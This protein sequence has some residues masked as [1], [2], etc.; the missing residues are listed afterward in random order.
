MDLNDKRKRRLFYNKKWI[1]EKRRKLIETNDDGGS[2]N[3]VNESSSDASEGNRPDSIE[4]LQSCNAG[5]QRNC[6]LT[7]QLDQ[8]LNNNLSSGNDAE[9]DLLEL[10]FENVYTSSDSAADEDSSCLLDSLRQ[11]ANIYEVKGNAIDSLLK[12][13]RQ[14]GH[15]NIPISSRTLL[16]TPRQVDLIRV[17]DMDY[18]H[19][20]LATML[21]SAL[22]KY[23][24]DDV[25]SLDRII[26]S[27]NIDGFPLFKSSNTSVWPVLGAVTNLKPMKP[28]LIT[29]T[30][31]KSKPSNL[32][33]LNETMIDLNNLLINGFDYNER[34]FGVT[35]SCIICDAPAK[36]FVKRVKQYSGY[37]GC[38]KC[39]Q[40]GLYIGRMTYPET[41]NLTYRTDS[42]FRNQ[43]QEEHHK[44]DER[45]PFLNLPID[46][47][48][49]F[50]IDYMHQ[51]CLGVMKKLIICWMRGPRS[52]ARL[53]GGLIDQISTRLMSFVQFVPREF[54]RKPR[55]LDE[56]DRWKATEFRQ[57]LLY[58]GPFALK[59]VLP[60]NLYKH[61]MCLS[62]AVN[63]LV[64]K[65][66]ASHHSNY[67][68]QLLTYFV[69][70][71]SVLYGQEF[72]VY[73]IHSLVHLKNEADI[74][75]CLDNCAAWPFESYMQQL[76]RKVRMGNNPAAQL[77]KRV[78]ESM[79]QVSNVHTTK[80]NKIRFKKPNNMYCTDSGRYCEVIRPINTEEKA[81]LCRVYH[82]SE[83]SFRYPCNSDIIGHAKFSK[84]NYN[85]KTLAADKLVIRCM[86]LP[87]IEENKVVFLPLQHD[88]Q[89]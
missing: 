17:S 37:Y 71:C 4:N 49:D 22:K 53:S 38:D 66:L 58:T 41:D 46:M 74:F 12:I 62:V 36:A 47:V 50:P 34:H 45:S 88:F 83:Y 89:V 11:W 28:F 8:E 29:V 26:I 68:H 21:S 7:N 54:A 25:Q 31:G 81:F 67:A 20:G 63:I 61:F 33:F 77:V 51:V 5:G 86:R 43:N 78:H 76:K 32:D 48:R 16:K 82:S 56:I 35:L 73:N 15:K 75:G 1:S 39:D 13:L 27:L 6:A 85:I 23:S 30:V 2:R 87:S 10:N 70:R 69:R 65:T 80:C 59:N 72:C 40:R 57:F 42:S 44:P 9:N 55:R 52:N 79:E 18:F 60:N 84:E 14:N 24:P 19:F 64:N 3:E